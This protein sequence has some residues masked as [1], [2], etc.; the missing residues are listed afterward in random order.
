M[1]LYEVKLT[2]QDTVR[3]WKGGF[4][5]RT[6]RKWRCTPP[7]RARKGVIGA[8]TALR[9][10]PMGVWRG[11]R[12]LHQR[13]RPSIGLPTPPLDSYKLH[14]TAKERDKESWDVIFVGLRA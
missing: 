11:D 14:S 5:T 9:S 6:R 2:D 8:C 3:G 4:M 7:L 10:S 12:L 13:H 1:T